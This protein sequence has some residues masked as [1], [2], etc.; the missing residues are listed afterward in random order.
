MK[1]PSAR[2]L[3]LSSSKTVAIDAKVKDL[4]SQ[5]Q[6]VV[7]LGAGEPEES[8]PEF[9]REAA[10]ASINKG[11]TKYTPASGIQELKEAICK[12]FSDHNKLSFTPDQIVVSSGAKH[13]IFHTLLALV[14][15][16]DE[17]II[18]SPYWVTYPELVMLLGAVPVMVPTE[19]D[20]G[21]KLNPKILNR[22]I[23]SRTKLIILNSPCNPT[24][25]VYSTEEIKTLADI[26]VQRDLY[27][28]SDE[29]YE[30]ILYDGQRH[31]SI[32]SVHEDMG[33]RTVV[34]NGVSKTFAMTGWRIG[35]SAAPR[36]LAGII[37]SIQGHGSLHP[38]NPSQYAA[39]AALDSDYLFVR[40]MTVSLSKKR[41][42]V[43][44]RLEE[45]GNVKFLV[46]SGAFYFFLD[47]SPFLRGKKRPEITT[48]EDLCIFL[49]DKHLL[50]AVPGTAF[51]R[52][53]FIRISFTA[54]LERIALGMD[55]LGEGL[56]ELI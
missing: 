48:S 20:D 11:L 21:F 10:I 27:C 55:R 7:N 14:N 31:V 53:N 28:L 6:D 34:I 56:G 46:P 43:I 12:K 15:P 37:G 17:V 35:Y 49:L 26:I 24:G 41:Q 32:A 29:I 47:I 3:S 44:S 50:A 33:S 52:E 42:M 22:A 38:A 36:V 4:I 45:M 8:T 1:P 30:H 23:T 9:I 40:D 5:G 25:A 13:S 16:G 2:I 19:F 54:P 39:I 51:G 18:P